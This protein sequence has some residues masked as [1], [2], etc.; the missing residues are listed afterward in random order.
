MP[1]LTPDQ[2]EELCRRYKAGE[3]MSALAREYG[4]NPSSICDLLASRGIPRHPRK[5]PRPPVV[6]PPCFCEVCGAGPLPRKFRFCKPCKVRREADYMNEW[7]KKMLAAGRCPAC[8]GTMDR[9][10]GVCQHCFD[11]INT[12]RLAKKAICFAGY[13]GRCACCGEANPV[14]LSIDHVNN[15]GAERRRKGIY[16]GTGTGWHLY[17]WLIKHKF[18]PGYQVLCFNCQWGKRLCGICPH[19]RKPQS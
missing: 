3:R 1:F 16:P 12:R 9:K 14:F 17:Y 10:K 15:D 19:Q 4:V 13:G 8:G 5:R 7:R 6:E 11:L 2:R 18:P